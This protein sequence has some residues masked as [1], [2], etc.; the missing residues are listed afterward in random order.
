MSEQT[1][2]ENDK[3]TDTGSEPHGDDGNSADG[4]GRDEQSQGQDGPRFTEAPDPL[5]GIRRWLGGVLSS[6]D[7]KTVS[8]KTYVVTIIGV[9]VLMM[10]A[11][12]GG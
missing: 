4:P 10:L 5:A 11:R 2:R 9:V 8:M 6:M 3:S 7:G 1:P 12:C